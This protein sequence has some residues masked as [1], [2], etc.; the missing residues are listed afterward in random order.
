MRHKFVFDPFFNIKFIYITIEFR[1]LILEHLIPYHI[2]CNLFL[3]SISLP[4]MVKLIPT[5]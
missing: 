5:I 4:I 3:D 2:S 1:S